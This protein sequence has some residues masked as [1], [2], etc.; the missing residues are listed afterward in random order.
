MASL[1]KASAYSKKKN[2]P[3][4]R[5]SK[6]KSKSYIKQNP[7]NK[8]VKYNL[9]NVELFNS[10]KFKNVVKFISEEDVLIRDNAIESGRLVINKNLEKKLPK[11]FY[12]EIKLFPH[13]ILRNNKTAAGA[14]ADRLSSGMKHSFGI[15]E[16]RA[17]RV[18]K[19]KE[20]FIVYCENEQGIKIIRDIFRMVKA[21]V[22]CKTKIIVEKVA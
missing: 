6:N 22:P 16:G 10:G 9:G 18:H 15:I 8:I 14:G 1:R 19:G 13:H 17:A 3:Y 4:T 20:I 5:Q 7:H 21:K 12:F 2:R 11:Q